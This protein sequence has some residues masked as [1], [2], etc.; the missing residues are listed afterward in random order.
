MYIRVAVITVLIWLIW[1]IVTFIRLNQQE[2]SI[3]FKRAKY[4]YSNPVIK[5]TIIVST[6]KMLF[7]IIRK[8][9]FKF[10]LTISQEV[11][12]KVWNRDGGKCVKC[13]SNENLEFDHIIPF[14]KGGG[15]TYRN[16]QLLCEPCN[17]T[18]S[19]K[20]G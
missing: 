5:Q 7:K 12:D 14:S 17:R 20:I 1:Y 19:N 15:N 11:K 13:G 6:L 9:F 4:F 16:I 10:W 2:I 3:I 8:S 18:K